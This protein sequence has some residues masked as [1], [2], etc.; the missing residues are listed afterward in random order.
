MIGDHWYEPVVMWPSFSLSAPSSCLKP[1]PQFLVTTCGDFF[2]KPGETAWLSWARLPL[3]RICQLAGVIPKIAL[4]NAVQGV[5]IAALLN[6]QLS[7][8]RRESKASWLEVRIY[9]TKG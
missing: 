5:A 2:H 1:L 7:N 9:D 3:R 6:R 4:S 8:K